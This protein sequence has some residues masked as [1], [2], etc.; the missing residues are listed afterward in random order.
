MLEVT[1]RSVRRWRQQTKHP[2][3]RHI[4]SPS[5]RPRKLAAEQ[6]KRLE[7]ALD[8]GAHAF[9]YAEDYWTLDRIRQVIWQLFGV[10]YHRSAVWHVLDRMDWSSQRPQ[11]RAL[12]RDDVAIEQWKEHVFPRIKKVS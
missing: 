9:G 4:H 10:R 5:G 8:D 1:P 6:E 2:K 12:R 11:R 3:R 7:K